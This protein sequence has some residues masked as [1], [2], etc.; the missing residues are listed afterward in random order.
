MLSLQDI[1][2]KHKL[3]SYDKIKDAAIFDMVHI[4][5]CTRTVM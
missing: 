5:A 1:Q 4:V 3:D 2:A